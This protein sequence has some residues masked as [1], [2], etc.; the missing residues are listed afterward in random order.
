[1]RLGIKLQ[2]EVIV[3]YGSLREGLIPSQGWCWCQTTPLRL[4]DVWVDFEEINGALDIGIF[5]H[6]RIK[7]IEEDVQLIL[8]IHS[9]A[10]EVFH[11][12]LLKRRRV[13]GEHD[14]RF[15][16]LTTRETRS[17]SVAASRFVFRFLEHDKSAS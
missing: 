8:R 10:V 16:A 4:Q 13:D 5:R 2:H 12:R 1:M 3:S 9:H 15:E 7:R 17:M 11:H 6:K 14:A